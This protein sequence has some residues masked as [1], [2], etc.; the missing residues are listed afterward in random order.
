MSNKQLR[1]CG[2]NDEAKGHVRALMEGIGATPRYALNF[3]SILFTSLR[4]ILR[5]TVQNREF[6]MRLILKIVEIKCG[7]EPN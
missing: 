1:Y 4:L 5:H 6:E 2:N 7:D 3:T